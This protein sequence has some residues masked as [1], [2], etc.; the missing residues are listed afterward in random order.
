MYKLGLE[1]EEEPETKLP[2]S[3]GSQKMQQNSG[4]TS[5]SASLTMLKSLCGQQKKWEI[6]KEMG[7]PDHLTCLLRK[8]Y[9]GQEATVKTRHGTKG[10]FEIGVRV[11]YAKCQAG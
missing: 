5:T 3:A 8:P 2:T 4:K 10:W 9:V 6:L 11:H 7:I 1:K